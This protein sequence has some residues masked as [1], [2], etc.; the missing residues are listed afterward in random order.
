MVNQNKGFRFVFMEE[1]KQ[2]GKRLGAGRKPVLSKKKQ[3]S[4]YVEGS[5]IIKFGNEEKMK[6]QIYKFI[7]GFGVEV[8]YDNPIS[9]LKNLPNYSVHD[10]YPTVEVKSPITGLVPKLSL[11][12][13]FM[14]ELSKATTIPQVEAI[15]K[16]AKGEVFT[17]RNKMALE[18]YA[19][20]VSR[21]MFND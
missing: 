10:I 3:I 14:A 18:S 17:P 11:F 5:K 12:D 20:E 7:D 19:K 4:L 16:R 13:D 21:P 1:K 6:V 8:N 15:M 2:G 9:E